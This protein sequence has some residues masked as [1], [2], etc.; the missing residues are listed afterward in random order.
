MGPLK[1][2]V[3]VFLLGSAARLLFLLAADQPLLYTHQY[4]YFT[5]AARIAEHPSPL[6]YIVTSEEWRTWDDVWTIAPAYFVFLGALLKMTGLQLWPVLVLQCVLGGITAAGVAALGRDLAG[7]A[8]LLGGTIYALYGP[9]VEIASTTMT[10]N[11]H[12]P[13]L[14]WAVWLAARAA[15]TG[16]RRWPL[17]A[18]ALIGVAALARSVTTGLLGLAALALWL[19]HGRRG[20]LPAAWLLAGGAA[21]ILPWTARNAFIVGDA[22]LIE[23][24]AF[25]N[26]WYANALF[27]RERRDRQFAIIHEQADPRERR[28]I[29]L[30][31]ALRGI[32]RHPGAFADKVR[33]NFWHF[34]R[35]EGLHNLLRIERSQEGWR[36]AMALLLDDALF[37]PALPLLA[38]FLVAGRASPAR[39][40]ILLWI[41][42]YLFLLVVVFHNEIRY[43]SAFVP[44]LFAAV[45]PGLLA[46]RERRRLA[47]IAAAAGLLL[48]TASVLPFAAPAC[49]ALKIAASQGEALRDAREGRTPEAVRATE[50]IAAGA[51]TSPRPWIRLG[52]ALAQ[53]G[54]ALPALA[55]FDR[56]ARFASP[57][58]WTPRLVRPQLLHELGRHAEAEAALEAAHLISW[59]E[60]PWLAL[61][62]A[63]RAVPAPHADFIRVGNDDYGAVRGFLHPRGGDPRFA[64]SRREWNRYERLGHELPP[65]GTHRWS[66]HRAWLRLRPK[67]PAARYTARLWIGYAF[68]ATRLSGRVTV[69]TTDGRV[70]SLAAD[71]EVRPHAFPVTAAPDGTVLVRLD[72]PTWSRAGEPAD[73][74]V[75]VDRF[76]IAPVAAP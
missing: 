5:N 28:S 36:H 8:G 14:V 75:R 6:T 10:E 60:D 73:Q 2:L 41:A 58:S 19:R 25:E 38:A 13:L 47:W 76:E 51:P 52:R 54:H 18:G 74:G 49:R 30:H 4:T 37:F 3:A 39:T 21:V 70:Y 59:G 9:A 67:T 1:P 12:T 7:R 72:A 27:D 26:I 66:R 40:L 44:F 65:V 31:F 62:V 64:L 61:E 69:T 56:A 53:A 42:Y 23:S 63:W 43:R 29:A 33:T 24:A 16:G 11:L 71:R 22:V 32:R 45:A 17:A 35:P 46:L 34:F 20:L 15:E 57:A 48:A 50:T 68:P 55:S